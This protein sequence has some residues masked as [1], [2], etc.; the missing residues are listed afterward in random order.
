MRKIFGGVLLAAA[1]AAVGSVNAEPN[2][3][4]KWL[5]ATPVTLWDKGMGEANSRADRYARYLGRYRGNWYT[6][7]SS[8]SFDKNEITVG[9]EIE[10]YN[11]NDSGVPTHEDCN[12]IRRYFI[13]NLNVHFLADPSNLNP[14]VFSEHNIDGIHKSV[15]QWFS[16]EGFSRKSRD[17]DIGEKLARIIFVEVELSNDAGGVS[18]RDR[19]TS[20]NAA[21]KPIN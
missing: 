18:C 13:N 11:E 7:W 5:M 20:A 6:G 19:I 21:S 17:K 16:H 12:R 1:V 2:E 8:Y 14:S 15:S 10:G 3:T 4:A 9:M